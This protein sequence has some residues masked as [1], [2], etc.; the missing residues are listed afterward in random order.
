MSVS[1]LNETTVQELL[2]LFERTP[3]PVIMKAFDDVDEGDIALFLL[4]LDVAA[5]N[6]K[7]DRSDEIRRT[8]E[9]DEDD[10]SNENVVESLTGYAQ[11][12]FAKFSYQRQILIAEHLAETEMVDT[13]QAQKI[14]E[15]VIAK[16]KNLL[17]STLF[18]G[19][20]PKN[21][22]KFLTKID[23]ERQHKIMEALEKRQP[24]LAE[25]VADGMFAFEDLAEVP[26]EV[27]LTLMQVLEVNTIALALHNAP[28]A[29]QD[30]FYQ[31]MSSEKAEMVEAE[32]EK[33]PIEQRQLG[34]TA[35]Q[36]VVNLVRSFAAKG[37]LK[38]H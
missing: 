5:T 32:C 22:A 34:K 28:A 9:R 4:L 17:T 10:I 27:I 8:L 20:G 24:D 19:N 18:F 29:I 16:M 11:E 7:A 6:S 3:L 13:S 23:T 1:F 37:L 38:I 35:Q 25:T 33:L 21:L 31:C 12:I 14:W 26:D 36:S 15:D 30:R 2:D